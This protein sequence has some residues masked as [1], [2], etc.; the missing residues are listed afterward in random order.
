MNTISML[1]QVHALVAAK[2]ENL[3]A[4]RRLVQLRG[5]LGGI[6]AACYLLYRPQDATQVSVQHFLSQILPRLLSQLNRTTDLQRV[7]LHDGIRGRID[8]TSTAKARY[9]TNSGP[10]TFVCRQRHR[11]FLRPENQ[12]VQFMLQQIDACLNRVPS[13]LSAWYAWI[14]D[15]DTGRR[16]PYVL[17]SGLAELARQLHIA[18]SSVYLRDV[19]PPPAISSHH[20]LA[21]RTSKNELYTQV[22]ELH[23]LYSNVVDA[24]SWSIW[25]ELV[26]QTAL[27][28]PDIEEAT[29]QL[30]LG[31]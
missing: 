7:E 10:A 13:D 5:H 18:R 28:P 2:P 11:E 12:L 25:A 31:R 21:A 30:I 19:A 17:A 29:L 9:V 8:W 1:L 4:F 16:Q 24:N 23:A 3:L 14:P 22:A 20:I 15:P 6:T 26:T 27:L